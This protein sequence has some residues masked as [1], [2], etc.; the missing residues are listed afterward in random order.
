MTLLIAIADASADRELVESARALAS[1]AR[2]DVR[3]VHVREPDVPEPGSADLEGLDVTAI[4]GDPVEALT[5]LVAGTAVDAFAFGL[6]C[7]C[8]SGDGPGMGH[9]AQ[10]LLN[11]HVAPV[12]LV[13]SGMRP[14]AGL[15]RLY[16]PLE[17]SPSTSAAMRA[18]DDALCARGREI[19]MLHVV[20]GDTPAEIGSLPAPRMMDQEHYEWTAWQDEFTMRFSQCPRGGRH[21]VAVRVGDPAAIIAEQAGASGAELIV[22]SWSG[23]FESGHGAV[24]KELLDTAPCPLLLVPSDAQAAV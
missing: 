21:R 6:R 22:L 24:I 9:V 18:A 3:A 5:K 4:D 1:A 12:L 19:V 13:R 20:T 10:A 15:K 2:W 23:S 8:G 17:G 16:V 7:S 11:G 14:V